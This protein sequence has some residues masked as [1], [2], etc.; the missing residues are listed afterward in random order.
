MVHRRLWERAA[1]VRDDFTELELIQLAQVQSS[2]QLSGKH[3]ASCDRMHFTATQPLRTWLLSLLLEGILLAKHL[4]G[5]PDVAPLI[6]MMP[7]SAAVDADGV[8][9]SATAELQALADKSW[10]ALM[11]RGPRKVSALQQARHR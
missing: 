3:S 10:A 5:S 8:G 7:P 11:A 9:P 4:V 6:G 2:A 1:Q